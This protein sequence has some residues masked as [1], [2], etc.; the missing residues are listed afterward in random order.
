MLVVQCINL[1]TRSNQST[2]VIEYLQS[3]Q[4]RRTIYLQIIVSNTLA[5]GHS[6]QNSTASKS[7]IKLSKIARYSASLEFFVVLPLPERFVRKL[8]MVRAACIAASRPPLYK[9]ISWA[10][11]VIQSY[12]LFV[13]QGKYLMVILVQKR[14]LC[15][16][17]F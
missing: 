10:S 6:G 9:T 7:P 16:S 15:L 3:S 8:M 14:L 2:W 11:I 5:A 1:P 17:I 12:I 13:R 4:E